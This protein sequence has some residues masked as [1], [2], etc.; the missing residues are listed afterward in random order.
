MQIA[1]HDRIRV[2][3][4]EIGRERRPVLVVDDFLSEPGALVDYAAEQ[5]LFKPGAAS[6]PGIQAT[7][8]PIYVEALRHY[9]A[10]ILRDG[11]GLASETAVKA[12]CA[13]SLVT[14]PPSELDLA[15]RLPHFDSTDPEQIA[16]LHYL[17]P[18]EKG[19]TAFYRHRRTGFEAVD[20]SR[21]A[22][23]TDAVNAELRELGMPPAA[24]AH[25]DGAQF[26]R[27]AT[28]EARFNRLIAYRGVALH[29]ASIAPGYD[30]DP[31][32]RTGRLTANALF[33]FSAA[34]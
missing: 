27:I 17:C 34:G 12:F 23:Y 5:G 13:F 9:M 2:E 3:R 32:P 10:P 21:V 26:E 4:H 28:C 11:L 14:T 33:A 19:G 24:Y 8:P 6:Y 25:G 7:V 20:T 16:L 1:L 18:A 31:N 15:Q 22:R 30:L 29:S